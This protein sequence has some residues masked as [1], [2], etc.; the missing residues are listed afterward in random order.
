MLP[1]GRR[2]GRAPSLNAKDLVAAKALVSDLGITVEKVAKR[3]K[4]SSATVYRHL[5]GGREAL[6]EGAV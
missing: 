6:S 1:H 2:G 5:P 4:V 3:L